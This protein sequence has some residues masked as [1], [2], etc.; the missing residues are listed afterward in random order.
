LTVTGQVDLRGAAVEAITTLAPIAVQRGIEISLLG[1]ECPMPLAGNHDAIVLALSNLIE[2]ALNYAPSGSAV[3][4]VAV[5]PATISVRDSGPGIPPEDIPRLLQPFQRGVGA[6]MGGA[7][8]GL[9]I[10]SRIAAAHGGAIHGKT[11]PEGGCDFTLTFPA[12]GI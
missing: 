6:A 3:E 11:R 10:V 9:A 1:P 4:I 8:L 7:G 2:N 12:P 5:R